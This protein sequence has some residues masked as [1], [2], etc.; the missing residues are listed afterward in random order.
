MSQLSLAQIDSVEQIRARAADWDRLWA[1]SEVTLPTARA[2][3]VAQ[4]L[5]HFAQDAKP[6]VLVV[7]QD[8]RMV[9]ALPLVGHRRRHVFSVGD[10]TWNYWS[11][12]GELLLDPAADAEA[13]LEVL[14]DAIRRLPWSLLWLELVPFA[15]ARWETLF[16]TLRQRGLAVHVQP[17]YKI[18]Q[19]EL[20]GNFAD[21]E[22]SRSR[23]LRRS[24]R[25]DKQ[26][27]EREGPVQWSLYSQFTPDEVESRLRQ[28]FEIENRSWKH[29][30][31]QTVLRTPGML[32]FYLRETQQLAEWG[33]LRLA[34]LEHARKPIAFELG[35]VAKNVYHSFKVGFDQDYRNFGPGHL[36]RRR[37]IESFFQQPD[38][39]V[40][41][42]QGPLTDALTGWS[43]RM[44]PIGRVLVG[45][46]SLTGRIL[47]AGYR[48]AG[49]V[50]RRL[51]GA[52]SDPP[53]AV[54]SLPDSR[55]PTDGPPLRADLPPWRL[56]SPL[57][58]NS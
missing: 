2:E 39:Q 41:D 9:G 55:A 30:A 6:Y 34:F 16:K 19:V 3:L 44:Y 43:T 54:V 28:A 4:W 11:P 15:T 14:A 38:V 37:L 24:L 27:L 22:A 26:R 49:P 23:N 25:K 13:V 56:N 36:L 21:Y 57:S 58:P 12:N 31:G 40:V 5:E 52:P 29:D 42:F 50:V 45:Q 48:L 7:E 46:P 33:L 53:G 20:V 10:L 18:G 35:W 17:H 1:E 47:T 51:R 32:G 8:G